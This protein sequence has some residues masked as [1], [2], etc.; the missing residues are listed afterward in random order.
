MLFLRPRWP[1]A[2]GHVLAEATVLQNFPPELA[3]STEGF[4]SK[5]SAVSAVVFFFFLREGVFQPQ[6]S[7]GKTARSPALR[8]WKPS[9]SSLDKVLAGH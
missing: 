4:M 7:S 2:T 5:V 3:T 8:S 1:P 6:K 9:R